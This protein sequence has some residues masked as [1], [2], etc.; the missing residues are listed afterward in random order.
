MI[1][2]WKRK[3]EY[4]K[5]LNRNSSLDLNLKNNENQDLKDP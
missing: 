5:Y 4:L 1:W 3:K 2:D